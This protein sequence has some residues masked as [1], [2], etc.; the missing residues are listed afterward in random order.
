MLRFE[1]WMICLC[2]CCAACIA[3]WS[4]T[5]RKRL[6]T[7]DWRFILD[8]TGTHYNREEN[9]ADWRKLRLPHDWSIEGV[10]SENNPASPGGG[11]LPGGTGWYR[12]TFTLPA[13]EKGKEVYV[14]FDGVYC[15]SEVWINGHYL[16]KRPNGYISFQ[17]ALTPWL[18]YGKAKN[19][20]AVKVDN[21]QQPNSRWYS[22][23]G[24]YRN[25]WLVTTSSVAVDHWGTYI[26]TPRIDRQMASVQIATRLRNTGTALRNSILLTTVYDAAGREIA[27]QK[28]RCA[29]P[30]DTLTC[31]QQI[32]VPSPVLWSPDQP[33]LYRV[34]TRLMDG[35]Q[36]TDEYTTHFGIRYF[37]FDKDKGFFL[38]GTH[39]KILGVC[40]HH[41]LGCLGTAINTRAL[42]R[43][44]QLLKTM[45]CNGIR[46]SHNPP[47]PELLDLCDKMGFIVIDEAFDMWARQKTPYDYHLHWQ[48]YHQRDLEDQVLR[49]RNHPSIFLWSI[50]NE[51]PE[52]WGPDTSGRNMARELIAIV[53][54]LDT[55]RPIVTANNE[56]HA[57]NNLLQSGAFDMAG[58]NYSHSQWDSFPY[59]WPGKKLI[60]TESVSALA[61]RGHYDKI[62]ADS[63]RRWPEAWD[64]PVKDGNADFTISAYDHVSTP[65]GSTHEES[66]KV[67]KRLDHVSGMYI[68]T[69]FDYLG[70]PTP[71]TWPARSSYFGIIDLAGF[72][73]DVYYMYQSE[74]TK[75]PVLH[76]LPHWNWTPGDTIDVAA[77]YSQAEEVE[78]YLNGQSLG[79]R[80]K[81]T[82][83]LHVQW[84]VPYT[85]GVLKAVSRKQGK[86]ILQKEIHTAG[87]PAAIR[88]TADRK[89]IKA[90]GRD[91]AF[92]TVSITDTNGN[93]VPD[94]DNLV[95]FF[96]SGPGH[97]A[98]VDNGNPISHE[99][100]KADHRKA[101]NGLCLAVIQ[102]GDHAGALTLRA[103]AGGLQSTQLVVQVQ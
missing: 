81:G 77:Y 3:A 46:T 66:W 61:T 74:W 54:K 33:Y 99:S 26:T 68:W 19:V 4:Q 25:V 73:K 103:T 8:S 7:D 9:D 38:N 57:W 90:D 41:D 51:I 20:I 22:G 32:Q 30:V 10:F 34:V 11:A 101:M 1:R 95:Q 44:L 17:Y 88:L 49:D 70:E 86:T 59:A 100:F 23:S 84:R 45:G 80:K 89:K 98:G 92:I 12:K 82:D 6:F 48:E 87:A 37:S 83:D 53:Q 50:G 79:I 24:I 72:P 85:P 63:I 91:L 94:A 42:E 55:T 78:L 64:K 36:L 2:L 52:Q 71:Y 29:L 69:G 47:A 76:L 15:N 67:L 16:G 35:Q 65:W 28:Q 102:A 40:N 39:L 18:Q 31:V 75:T 27:H 62:P 96:I 58:Y 21:A 14:A 97:I 60:V 93:I 13:T 5:M 56:I 43:Q